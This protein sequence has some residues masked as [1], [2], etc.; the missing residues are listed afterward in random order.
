[1]L[2]TLAQSDLAQDFRDALAALFRGNMKIAQ[3]QVHIL[4]NGQFIDEVETLEH[5]ADASAAMLRAILF[6]ELADGFA[7]KPVFATVGI[8]KQSKDVKQRGLS[9]TARS[10][11]SHEL[12]V[13]NVDIH[14][15]EGHGFHF[16]R[17][18]D[19]GKVFC[20]YHCLVLFV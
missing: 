12:A 13:F 14:P 18:E 4:L 10:H 16:F 20:L 9:T 8:V 11:D 7:V 17:A 15:I 3:L 19:T 1:M 6:L 2:G 5:K